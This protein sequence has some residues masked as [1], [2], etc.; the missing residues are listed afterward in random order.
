MSN[1]TLRSSARLLCVHDPS[2][3]NEHINF[4]LS[5]L[6]IWK[7]TNSTSR[8]LPKI[9][10]YLPTKNNI[11]FDSLEVWALQHALCLQRCS[12]LHKMWGWCF[13]SEQHLSNLVLM[14]RSCR[15]VT[16]QR[17]AVLLTGTIH[18]CW[19]DGQGD[20]HLY[21][22][23]S[24]RVYD[25]ESPES[26]LSKSMCQRPCILISSRWPVQQRCRAAR[27]WAVN[28]EA[29]AFFLSPSL[30]GATAI[31]SPSL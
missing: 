19:S 3:S 7:R 6:W 13:R 25:S 28:V 30:S 9:H 5:N 31:S 22:G 1:C 26:W 27:L 14:R 12:V 20:R 2:G 4:H 17:S 11:L 15:M 24:C 16:A 29:I 23:S 18:W 10:L 21:I 8:N